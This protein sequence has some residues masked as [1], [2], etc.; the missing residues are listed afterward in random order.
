M[1]KDLLIQWGEAVWGAKRPLLVLPA[2]VDT[3]MFAAACALGHALS[4]A[5]SQ[6][7]ILCPRAMSAHA[8]FLIGHLFVTTSLEETKTYQCVIPE[9]I[10]V[11][12]VS[13]ELLKEGGGTI[14]LHLAHGT[15]S[16]G[17][18]VGAQNFAP[19]Q[20]IPT[21][22]AFD[23]I[24][25]LGAEDLAEVAP[26]FGESH[27]LPTK[28]PIATIAWR[29]SSETFGRWNV[30]YEQATTLSEAVASLLRET[31]PLSVKDHVATCL[32]AGII[33]KTKHF[34]SEL[35]TPSM[36][37]M[38][39]DLVAAGADRLKIIEELYRTRTVDSL[40]LWGAACA[41]LQEIVPGVLF[42]ELTEDDFL[43]THTSSDA[44]PD[45]AQEILQSSDATQEIIFFSQE[46]GTLHAYIAAKKPLD[47]RTFIGALRTE[48]TREAAHHTFKQETKVQD[49]LL[50]ITTSQKRS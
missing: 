46:K 50:N 35:V 42:S 36:L 49:V 44:L 28:T 12:R 29:P 7:T 26:L 33:A 34:R 23:R 32:L 24:I 39:A 6:V 48:G 45:I 30:V 21:V 1:A 11:E 16:G 47:A 13:H 18:G 31:S 14:T 15:M 3:D 38:S 8:Q 25:T 20:I 4:S 40:K 37:N 27:H 5:G 22:P 9:N 41:R 17:A 2:S 43:R 10:Q 19:L